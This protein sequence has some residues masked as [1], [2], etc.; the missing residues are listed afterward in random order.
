VVREA[1]QACDK[2]AR[3]PSAAPRSP[4]TGAAIARLASENTPANVRC[5]RLGRPGRSVNLAAGGRRTAAAIYA[6]H[7]SKGFIAPL[8]KNLLLIS[9][10]LLAKAGMW[11]ARRNGEADRLARLAAVKEA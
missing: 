1:N 8:R 9:N 2:A 4:I 11:Q 5:H 7:T 10:G 6:P 3:A